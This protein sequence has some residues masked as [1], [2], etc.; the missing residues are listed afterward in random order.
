MDAL[1]ISGKWYISSRR[2]AK[3]YGYHSDYIGQ[4]IRS[5]KVKGQKVGRSWYVLADSLSE[6]LGTEGK[7]ET[8]AKIVPEKKPAEKA[9]SHS[10][11][12][13]PV[14]DTA[15]KKEEQRLKLQ[16]APAAAE[17]PVSHGDILQK[18][19]VAMPIEPAHEAHQPESV[20]DVSVAEDTFLTYLPDGSSSVET[21]V[22]GET[23]IPIHTVPV[24]PVLP[25]QAPVPFSL[26]QAVPF[27]GA[28][29]T[30]TPV[31]PRISQRVSSYP[32]RRTA[33]IIFILIGIATLV[34][35]VAASLITTT[36][37]VF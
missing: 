20:P 15:E 12:E 19:E 9:V 37:S 31:A 27:V 6:Y 11:A 7:E 4:L 10:P 28:E 35:T 36:I 1:Q 3:E 5:G 18:F 29:E 34:L 23:H 17:E 25:A 8:I 26:R 24:A 33:P 21:P 32:E 16:A 2:A 13:Q 14:S 22:G 30:A